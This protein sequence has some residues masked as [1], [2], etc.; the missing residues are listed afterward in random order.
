LRVE[1]VRLNARLAQPQAALVIRGKTHQVE[2]Q[3]YPVNVVGRVYQNAKRRIRV[4]GDPLPM[5]LARSGQTTLK[6]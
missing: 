4:P 3:R 5:S 1:N 6:Q 2:G